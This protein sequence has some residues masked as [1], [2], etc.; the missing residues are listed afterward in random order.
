[1]TGGNCSQLTAVQFAGLC[2]F[3][4]FAHTMIISDPSA[5]IAY[6]FYYYILF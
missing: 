4:Q 6:R 2:N 5:S 3:K 1:M